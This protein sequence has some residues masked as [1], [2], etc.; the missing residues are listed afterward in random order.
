MTTF[1]RIH[2]D[3]INAHLEA[4]TVMYLVEALPEYRPAFVKLYRQIESL[5]AQ[6]A[7]Q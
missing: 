4:G 7:A 1:R 2:R 5:F 3:D 6:G